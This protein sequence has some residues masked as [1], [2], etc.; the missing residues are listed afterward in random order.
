MHDGNSGV[1]W[2]KIGTWTHF[3]WNNL[4][5]ESEGVVV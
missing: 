1:W 5:K 2:G 4:E 3:A